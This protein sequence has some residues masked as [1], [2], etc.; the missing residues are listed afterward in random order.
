MVKCLI[1]NCGEEAKNNS[2]LSHHVQGK[3]GLTWQDYLVKYANPS[4]F[5]KET[6]EE[7]DEDEEEEEKD[8]EKTNLDLQLSCL[9]FRKRFHLHLHPQDHHHQP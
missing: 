6:E 4:K 5:L 9:Q 1:P 2:G 8:G 7:R 3:H